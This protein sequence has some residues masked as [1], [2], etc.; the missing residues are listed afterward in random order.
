MRANLRR[1]LLLLAVALCATPA[2]GQTRA[3]VRDLLANPT[4][5]DQK[6][7]DVE[8]TIATISF[9]PDIRN[10]ASVF[11]FWLTDGGR[12]IRV[13]NPSA[14]VLHK[15]DRVQVDG[16]FVHLRAGS[17]MKVIADEI[18]AILYRDKPVP[19]AMDDLQRTLEA[20]LKT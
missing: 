11:S 1:P 7:V 18:E 12:P 17:Q 15:G 3:Q 6:V 8:G 13:L 9:L 14:V 20:N 4:R 2:W 19:A 10:G 16:T 5:Y